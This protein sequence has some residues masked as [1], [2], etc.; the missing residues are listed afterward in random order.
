MN[1][2]LLIAGF[3][4]TV[5]SAQEELAGLEAALAAAAPG[6][7]AVRAYTSGMVRR[8]LAARGRP[9]DSPAEALAKLKAAGVEEVFVQ[10]T[11][12]LCGIE[13]EKL[14]ADAAAA[15]PGFARL[16]VGRPLLDGTEAVR[17][18]AALLMELCPAAEGHAVVF[19]GHGTAAFANLAYPA[20]QTV[21]ELAGRPDL[22]VGTVEGWPGLEEARGWL[23]AH[24]A[25]R[26]VRLVPLLLAAGDHALH[27]MAGEDPGSWQSI[28]EKDGYE[29]SCTLRGLAAEPAFRQ[30][31]A[32]RMAGEMRQ[33]DGL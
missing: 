22:R 14:K 2:A 10:P 5:P 13:Y 30:F 7:Q 24:P 17:A 6:W 16:R 25:C 23:W 33:T 15:A 27:D 12:F 9:V 11:H 8:A 19:M 4:T 18:L 31:C 21:F 29:V 26:S 32:A 20:L 28:L 1:Q 3:G